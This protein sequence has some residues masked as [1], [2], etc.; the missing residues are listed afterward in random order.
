MQELL[1]QFEAQTHGIGEV[2]SELNVSEA[3]VRNWIK[4]GYLILDSNKCVTADSLSRF[5]TEIVGSQ[6]LVNRANKQ[7]AKAVGPA[8]NSKASCSQ[9][10]CISAD[11]E[12]SLTPAH[13]NREG[14][15]YTPDS[16]AD[17][18]FA[19]L[20]HDR[21]HL[22]FCDPCCGTGNFLMAAIR[23][24]FSPENV[25]G[26][27][28]DVAAV[29]IAQDRL[30]QFSGFSRSNVKVAD[31]LQLGS[32]TDADAAQFD[33][34]MT[35]PP[36]GKKLPKEQR[37]ALGRRLG[38]GKSID[39]CSLF[40]FAALKRLGGNGYCGMLL[41]ESFF[42]VGTFEEARRHVLN[43]KIISVSD[44]GK[45]FKGLLTKAVGIIL[46]N[47]TI[48]GEE[49]AVLCHSTKGA[50]HSRQHDSFA[51]NPGAIINFNTDTNQAQ[52]IEHIMR[53]PHAT[54]RGRARW[55]LGIVTGNNARFVK[56][57]PYP[58]H[59]PVWKGSDIRSGRLMAPSCYIP[60][61]MSI[62]QQV[63]PLDLYQAPEKMIY[64]FISNKLDFFR[65]DK[66]RFVLN[67][68]NIMIPSENF[69]FS[70]DYLTKYFNSS[71]MNWIFSS[72]FGTH[73]VLRGDLECLPLFLDFM[74]SGDAFC[75][76][77][78]HSYLGIREIE[79]GAFRIA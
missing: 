38:A 58:A 27:D 8:S 44:F 35:N 15:F 34:I 13:K 57:R 10:G 25:F 52:T 68:A 1:F 24:G 69:N 16:I 12:A 41:P 2:A 11:Y 61:D 36:W 71:L 42:N 49:H 60:E 47:D 74:E 33:V 17:R 9:S 30:S 14:I 45:P 7:F 55:G 72:I 21:E 28:T 6:K 53:Q 77:A 59:M 31:F 50:T 63:A 43:M 20:P 64:K 76:D 4:T 75:E 70:Q 26:F 29:A 18:F 73:K 65:D 46:R 66:Q 39:T 5:K 37:A 78:F 3:S 54:L 23:S 79:N 19:D 40:L 56:D 62:Y 51:R 48:S 22:T 32:I 67:S